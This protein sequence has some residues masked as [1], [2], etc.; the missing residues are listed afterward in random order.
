MSVQ[1]VKSFNAHHLLSVSIKSNFP[2]PA[3]GPQNV[4]LI[5]YLTLTAPLSS[6]EVLNSSHSLT[7]FHIVSSADLAGLL[8]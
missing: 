8:R 5:I 7:L 6:L 1:L 3:L 2:P 4:L